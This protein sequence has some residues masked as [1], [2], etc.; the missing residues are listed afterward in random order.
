MTAREEAAAELR[1]A[2]ARAVAMT[3]HELVEA[4]CTHATLADS[5]DVHARERADARFKSAAIAYAKAVEA[6]HAV[7]SSHRGAPIGV[8]RRRK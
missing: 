3:W 4:S 6:G 8:L 5:A 7:A 2:A 1:A